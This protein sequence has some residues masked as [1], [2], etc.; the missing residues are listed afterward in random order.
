MKRIYFD[1]EETKITKTKGYI[2]IDDEYIQIYKSMFNLTSRLKSITDVQLMLYLAQ[3]S[4]D[5]NY[6]TSNDNLFNNFNNSLVDKKITKMTFQRCLL[7]LIEAKIAVKIGKGQYQLNP[8]VI[9]KDALNEREKHITEILECNSIKP[10][11]LIEPK[12]SK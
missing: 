4:S 2:E 9:W 12:L 5:Y 1:K 8:F 11:Y 7:N 6:F 10:Q 3:I